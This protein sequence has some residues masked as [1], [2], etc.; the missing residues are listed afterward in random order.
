MMWEGI[1]KRRFPRVNYK[2]LI[3]ISKDRQ[4][5]EVIDTYTENIG[6]GG[7]CVTLDRGYD[8]FEKVSLEIHL[9][10][11]EPV[12]CSGAIVWV[13]K[14]HPVHKWEKP[15]Y[16]TGIEFVDINENDRERIS[17]LVDELMKAE[18]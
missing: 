1:N 13:V 15:M 6:A 14:G 9:G 4:Q 10:G 16:D 12:H 8:L 3:R 5:E 17:R 7:I 2:C 11:D 18:A